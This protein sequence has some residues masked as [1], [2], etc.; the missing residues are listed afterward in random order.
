[1]QLKR[2]PS[3]SSID[4]ISPPPQHKSPTLPLRLLTHNVRYATSQPFPGEVLWEKRKLT[5]LSHLHYHT[6]SHFTPSSTLICLQEVLHEQLLDITSSLGKHWT[7]VGVGRDDG[8]KAGEYSPILFRHHFWELVHFETIWLSE[9]PDVPGRKGWDA[10]SVR[11]LTC[12]VLRCRQTSQCILALN[13]HLDDQGEI[14]R[15]ES[16]HLIIEHAQKL[17]SRFHVD[18]W[19]LAGDLNSEIDGA[20]Y[21]ILNQRGSGFAD[22]RRLIERDAGRSRMYGVELT[23]TGFGQPSDEEPKVIDFV[24]L[25]VEEEDDARERKHVPDEIRSAMVKSQ[26]QGYA[27]LPNRFDGGIFMS[28]HRAVVVDMMVQFDL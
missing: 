25:G 13:T 28:D 24:H 18:F 9:T 17:R 20:A 21:K 3:F 16:A 12:S 27:V 26:V 1:M 22:A 7:Y 23:F 10:A 19:F 8:R 5:F 4:S 6:R 14:S 11:I 15:R 2:I